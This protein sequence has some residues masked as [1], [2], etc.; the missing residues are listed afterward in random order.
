MG[1]SNGS[2]ADYW[3]AI[4]STH[5]LQ[6]GFIWEWWDH[7][8]QRRWPDGDARACPSG[9]RAA[10][11]P[12]MPGHGL[13]PKGY[14]WA[15]GGDFADEPND[16]NFVADRRGVPR[17]VPEARDVRAPRARLARADP[18]GRRPRRRTPWHRPGEPAGRPRPLVAARGVVRPLRRAGSSWCGRDLRC[19]CRTCPR[20]AR[21]GSRCRRS[22]SRRSR[23]T[24]TRPPRRG[25]RCACTPPRRRPAPPKERSS[26]SS[27][28]P[29]TRSG[30]AFSPGP[31]RS[32]PP[33]EGRRRRR[34]ARSPAPRRRAAAGPVARPH[35]QRPDRR[36]GGALGRA[37]ARPAGTPG[38]R[39]GGTRRQD[40]GDR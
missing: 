12:E 15:Y 21:P 38:R 22:C 11:L 3:D 31:A 19:G 33:A 17:P 29:S 2:L 36:D 30:V 8:L 37:G 24:R 4:E 40:S 39:G 14:R 32:L 5:G 23:R 26:P 13:P 16:G 20:V 35:R 6:G 10:G 7:G 34:V 1:N 25:C 28:C 9:R 27:S 18:S